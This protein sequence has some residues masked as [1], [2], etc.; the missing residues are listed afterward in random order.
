MA[1]NLTNFDQ[2]LKINYL[3]AIRE[4]LNNATVLLSEVS[5]NERDVSGKRWQ[6]VAH[7]ARNSGVGARADE[8]TLPS[9]GQQSYKNPYGTVAYNYGRIQVSGP[10]IAAA[11][12]DEGAIVRALESE[13]KGVTADLKK[14]INFQMF[15]DGSANRASVNGDPGTG[16]TLTIHAAYSDSAC[17]YQKYGTMYLQEGM[18]IDVIND[19]GTEHDSDVT[20][21]SVDSNTQVTVSAALNSSIA[22]DDN[23]VRA[24]AQS[25]GTS[26]EMMG[27]SG[28]VDDQSY[29]TTLHN[30]NRS[31][32]AWWDC[33]TFSNDDNSGTNR[34]L[35]LPLMQQGL[36]AVE[37]NGGK[38]DLILATHD[39]RDSYAELVIAD[40][41][42]VNSMEL[43]G[44]FTGL[45]YNGIPL[46]PD[47][48]CPPNTMFF[49]DLDHLFRMQMSD[50]DWMDKDG[51]ILNRVA[52][53]DAY[54]AVLYLYA[55]MATDKPRAFSFLRDVK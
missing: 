24:G 14:D 9:A 23:I 1:Q 13:I 55:D 41:R 48:D 20:I 51:A 47:V 6:L 8:G 4:Q 5:V 16:T 35:T 27:L 15:S 21:S 34:D 28:I 44:G 49:L 33:S 18:L 26:Y 19:A 3:P 54:E 32:N 2:A 46:V 22:D 45:E 17:D 37:K 10:T 52:N 53:T 30:I 40:K 31:N 29:V 39:L 25:S 43:D 50:F 12:N 38:T 36:T 42:H 7:H 11:R